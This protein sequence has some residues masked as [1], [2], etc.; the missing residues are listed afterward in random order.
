MIFYSFIS[1]FKEY[2]DFRMQIY[3]ERCFNSITYMRQNDN[4]KVVEMMI[5]MKIV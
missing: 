3:Y 5:Y 4:E 1:P 2:I